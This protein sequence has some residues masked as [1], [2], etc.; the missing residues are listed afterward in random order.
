MLRRTGRG[1]RAGGAA[2]LPG[3]GTESQD[4]NAVP[5]CFI[6]GESKEDEGHMR[7][8]SLGE[9]EE[10]IDRERERLKKHTVE[11]NEEITFVIVG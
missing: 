2:L 7:S 1:A 8:T 4:A 10:R 9:R 5:R 3:S 6:A 11:R